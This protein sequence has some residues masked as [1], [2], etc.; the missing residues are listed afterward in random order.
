MNTTAMAAAAT[1]P[2]R[3]DNGFL[4][5][6][7]W[8]VPTIEGRNDAGST[9]VDLRHLDA[10]RKLRPAAILADGRVLLPALLWFKTEQDAH[11]AVGRYQRPMAEERF[12][13]TLLV[14][15]GLLRVRLEPDSDPD[16][17]VVELAEIVEATASGRVQAAYVATEDDGPDGS[18]SPSMNSHSPR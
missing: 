13:G 3:R 15:V 6:H 11:E 7:E 5:P 1:R 16:R 14:E 18:P 4:F 12:R 8:D 17:L 9:F 2:E 10:P